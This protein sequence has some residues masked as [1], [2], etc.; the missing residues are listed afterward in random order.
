MEKKS[1]K[2]GKKLEKFTLRL[3]DV[4]IWKPQARHQC[5][6][7]IVAFIY[8]SLL[9][10]VGF[11][12]NGWNWKINVRS[13]TSWWRHNLKTGSRRVKG[14]IVVH[15]SSTSACLPNLKKIGEIFV[16]MLQTKKLSNFKVTW[17]ENE[18]EFQKSGPQKF[19][20]W[21]LLSE[22]EGISNGHHCNFEVTLSVTLTFNR[23][24]GHIV[25]HCSS[26]STYRPNIK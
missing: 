12:S 15:L 21:S 25:V 8:D 4:I 22:S 14:H 20:Y 16:L 26:T 9:N 18:T 10:S 7:S 5:L 19:R 2:V 1:E 11:K 24:K 17:L 23:V 3:H 13:V 6:Q